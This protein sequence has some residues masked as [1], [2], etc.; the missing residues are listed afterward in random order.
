LD[1]TV[2]VRNWKGITKRRAQ[3][4]AAGVRLCKEPDRDKLGITD[5][6]GAPR[7]KDVNITYLASMRFA[8]ALCC[9]EVRVHVP[10]EHHTAGLALVGLHFSWGATKGPLRAKIS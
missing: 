4:V 3:V 6:I 5:A 10:L 7:C 2:P 1:L 9:M 8:D